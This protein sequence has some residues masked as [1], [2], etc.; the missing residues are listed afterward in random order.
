MH[1]AW[2]PKSY[3]ISRRNLAGLR[4]P[5]SSRSTAVIAELTG[6]EI[7]GDPLGSLESGG[8]L[9][10]DVWRGKER[11]QAEKNLRSCSHDECELKKEGIVG[12]EGIYN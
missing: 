5:G 10:G 7:G 4:G 11:K 12:S 8:V 2:L 1:E 9:L 3:Q 6:P